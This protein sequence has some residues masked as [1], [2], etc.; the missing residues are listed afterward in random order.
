M[1]SKYEYDSTSPSG[2]VYK[3][4]A[5][6]RRK[7]DFAGSRESN[8]YWRVQLHG[9]HAQAHR[10]VWELHNGPIPDGLQ[11]DHIDRNKDNN[12]IENLRL[13]TSS[14]NN[15]N[16]TFKRYYL[17]PFGW[18]VRAMVDGKRKTFGT[19]KTEQEA[20]ECCELN[21]LV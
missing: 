11:V 6:N 12:T 2:L 14:T 7:G 21:G 19:F 18:R 16:R 20:I 15:L 5:G 17:T 4:H 9:K 8:G 1:H 13:A 3:I 10:V